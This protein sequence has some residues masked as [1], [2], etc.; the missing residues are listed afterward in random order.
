M[1]KII[2]HNFKSKD[3]CVKERCPCLTCEYWINSNP[4]CA[5]KPCQ[6][7]GLMAPEDVICYKTSNGKYG[8]YDLEEQI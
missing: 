4:K 6:Q 5:C 1:G 7:R 8:Y 3:W 2:H